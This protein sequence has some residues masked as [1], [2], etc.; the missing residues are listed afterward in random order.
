MGATRDEQTITLAGGCFW[1]VDAAFR[2]LDGVLD[3]TCGYAQGDLPRP[4]Y[5]DV[6]GGRTGHAEA[7]RLRFDPQRL[8]L[9]RVLEV[10]FAIH[11][12]TSRD[13]QGADVGP[14]Y[15]SG[16]YYGDAA[17]G[18]QVRAL[19]DALVGAMGP[20][21][22]TEVQPLRVFWPAEAEHQDYYARHPGQGYCQ[23]VIRPK[24]DAVR[25]G[26]AGLLRAPR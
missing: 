19:V 13:R 10:F 25:S 22:V 5:A 20:R 2:T 4:T 8:P 15:R 21:V 1:C 6:C 11:D 16:I 12:P 24:L 26:F 7:V 23:A 14:Q 3:T 18:E 17:Q 9:R